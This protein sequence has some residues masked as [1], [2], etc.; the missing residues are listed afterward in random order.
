MSV[1]FI[2]AI[3]AGFRRRPHDA[4]GVRS[5]ASSALEQLE[6]A[7]PIMPGSARKMFER[8]GRS[9]DRTD[10]I[11]GE[12]VRI[13]VRAD[14]AALARIYAVAKAEAAALDARIYEPLDGLHEHRSGGDG[15]K[16]YNL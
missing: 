1:L 12:I 3:V 6:A 16:P 5:R 2:E 10:P 13:L 8:L 14:A 11:I 7:D 15:T 9:P 4:F